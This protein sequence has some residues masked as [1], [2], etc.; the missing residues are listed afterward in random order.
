[1]TKRH[2]TFF[3][4]L[5]NFSFG[6]YFKEKAVQMAWEVSTKVLGIPPERIWVSV[7]ETDDDAYNL[8]KE[9]VFPKLQAI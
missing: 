5:G 9:K 7:F 1:M 8:W 3:E 2:H 4:M 6:D